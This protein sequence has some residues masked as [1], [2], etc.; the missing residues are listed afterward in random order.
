MTEKI[1][2]SLAPTQLNVIIAD[3]HQLFVESLKLLLQ[4]VSELYD[5]RIAAVAY[6]GDELIEILQQQQPQLLILD[7]NLPSKTGLEVLSIAKKLLKNTRILALTM[8]DDAKIIKSAFD[9]G[10][11]GYLLKNCG[12]AEF[13]AAIETVMRGEV[14][15]GKGVSFG[16][17]VNNNTDFDDVFQKKFSLTKREIEI[18]KLITLAQSNGSIAKELFISEQ[19]AAVHRKN[20]MRKM[21]V[22]S[23]AALIRVAYDNKQLTQS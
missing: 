19:T 23:T 11:D 16:N 4:Q 13:A 20:I 18:L 7:I 17:N 14:Y 8:Y 2:G 6:N 10:V 3:D 5:C 1:L 22:N 21:G 15:V 9:L 12:R